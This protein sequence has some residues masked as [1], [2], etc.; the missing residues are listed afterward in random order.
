[1]ALRFNGFPA[2]LFADTIEAH[3]V[4]LTQSLCTM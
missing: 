1:M 4:K 2:G 3:G